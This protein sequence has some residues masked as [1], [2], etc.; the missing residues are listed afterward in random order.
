M[1]IFVKESVNLLSDWVKQH[2]TRT[3]EFHG[4]FDLYNVENFGEVDLTNLKS[5][6]VVYCP[7]FN[8]ANFSQQW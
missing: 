6:T 1:K 4:N 3:P 7:F 2:Q 5:L 8:K